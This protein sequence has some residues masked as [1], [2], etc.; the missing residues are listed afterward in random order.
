MDKDKT[1]WEQIDSDFATKN[2]AMVNEYN[3]MHGL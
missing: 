2:E 1:S 3:K